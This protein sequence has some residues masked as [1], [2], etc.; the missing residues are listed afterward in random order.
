MKKRLAVKGFRS[1]L[2]PLI[3]L[4]VLVYFIYHL[5]QGERGLLSWHRLNKRVDDLQR[6]VSVLQSQKQ[7]LERRVFL[8]SPS[9]LCPDMLEERVRAVLNFVRKDEIVIFE[10][11]SLL[12]KTTQHP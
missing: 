3:L 7:T 1:L 6:E 9:S 8:L 5:I 2:V 11:E 12:K 4:S 10:D